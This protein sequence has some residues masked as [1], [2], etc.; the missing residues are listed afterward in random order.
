MY[1]RLQCRRATDRAAKRIMATMPIVQTVHSLLFSRSVSCS[2]NQ[3]FYLPTKT[4]IPDESK[5]EIRKWLD[6]GRKNIDYLMV[7]K[8]LPDWPAA[9]KVDGSAHIVGD[10]GFVFLFNPNEETLEATFPLSEEGIGLTAR[11][12]FRVWQ[13]HPAVDRGVVLA[14]GEVVRW[15]VPGETAVILEVGLT[16]QG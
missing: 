4:G 12:L 6:W 5:A 16:N 10:R 8:D 14:Y 2:P 15:Q 11:G 3:L 1:A 13:H 7:R 9:G